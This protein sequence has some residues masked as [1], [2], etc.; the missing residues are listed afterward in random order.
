M[1]RLIFYTILFMES[2]IIFYPM[3][4]KPSPDESDNSF[5]KT[6][7]IFGE[8]LNFIELGF[9]DFEDQ[10]WSHFGKNSHL[11]KCWC[12]IPDPNNM[13]NC[14]EWTAIAPKGYT[15]DFF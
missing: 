9:F 5:S 13:V 12:Y 15:K 6:V 8:K 10:Q 11:L 3:S 2:P 7:I 14:G 1:L 4:E